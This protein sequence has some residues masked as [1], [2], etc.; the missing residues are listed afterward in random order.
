MTTGKTCL[1]LSLYLT[2]NESR[3]GKNIRKTTKIIWDVLK[4]I[5]LPSQDKFKYIADCFE[6]L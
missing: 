6:L 5:S 3:V 4:D 1:V 2:K